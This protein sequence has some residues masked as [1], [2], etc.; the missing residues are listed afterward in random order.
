M[1]MHVYV[2]DGIMT[3][4]RPKWN[5]CVTDT[6]MSIYGFSGLIK[7]DEHSAYIPIAV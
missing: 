3:V 5:T 2:L 1:C 4:H 7:G 6:V